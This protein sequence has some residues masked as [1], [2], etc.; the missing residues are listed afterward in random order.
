MTPVVEAFHL[1]VNTGEQGWRF[2]VLHRPS[3]D[4]VRGTVLYAPPWAEEM[5]K[6]RRMAA[7]QARAFAEAGF[8][9]LLPDL[10]GCGDS[11]GEFQQARWD[12]WV[13]DLR[14]AALWLRDRLGGL[15]VLWGLRSGCLL[16]STLAQRL[17]AGP[18]RLLLW[19]PPS[20]GRTLLTQFLRLHAA[21]NVLTGAGASP[22]D[23]AR[24]ALDSGQPVN[25]AGYELNPLLA[26]GLG[27]AALLP[28]PAGSVAHWFEV[29]MRDQL[30]LLPATEQAR[31]D[32]VAAG[33]TVQAE[34]VRGPAFWQTVEIETVP[35][36]IGRSTAALCA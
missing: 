27:A 25:V 3:G 1:P 11:A 2:C 8:A 18:L 29:S 26:E 30:A 23:G 13:D 14:V 34:V 10:F 15:P 21:G 7:L 31:A 6:A 33:C 22:R 16:V 28:P 20:Q 9:T 35:D 32:W 17:D 19:Q 12:H 36:L 4:A 24:R 5:N